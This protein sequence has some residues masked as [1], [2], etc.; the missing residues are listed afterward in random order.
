MTSRF[1]ILLGILALVVVG[2]GAYWYADYSPPPATNLEMASST[3]DAK[4]ESRVEVGKEREVRSWKSGGTVV[5]LHEQDLIVAHEYYSGPATEQVLKAER[6]GG[7]EIVLAR[8]ESGENYATLIEQVYVSPLGTYVTAEVSGYESRYATTYLARTGEEVIP[9]ASKAIP[10]WTDDE[11]KVALIQWASGI[12]GT[13]AEFSYSSVG[14]LRHTQLLR[15]FPAAD[16]STEDVVQT[17]GLVTVTL[18]HYASGS[19]V[20]RRFLLDLQTGTV[21]AQ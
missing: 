6:A 4:T 18:R 21:T 15:E 20:K 16:Y 12:D 13:P 9:A 10:Y 7:Q 3:P 5:T 19:S 1:Q 11:K 2:A 8:Y 14:D 17:G